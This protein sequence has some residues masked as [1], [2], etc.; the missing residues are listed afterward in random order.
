M[1]EIEKLRA[2]EELKTPVSLKKRTRESISAKS[3]STDQISILISP[4]K[5]KM[6]LKCGAIVDKRSDLTHVGR[7]LLELGSNDPYTAVLVNVD[8]SSSIN[9]FF[10]IQIIL[11]D[12]KPK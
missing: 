4:T 8:I 11:H 6:M 12:E 2:D 10:M 5:T 3:N 9:N 7:V 1:D